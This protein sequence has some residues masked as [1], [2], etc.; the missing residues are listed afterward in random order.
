VL[1]FWSGDAS[2]LFNIALRDKPFQSVTY[3]GCVG[4]VTLTGSTEEIVVSG[5]E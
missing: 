5:N 1:L 4:V 2:D 3:L